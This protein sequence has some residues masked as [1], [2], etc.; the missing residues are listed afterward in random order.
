MIDTSE[1]PHLLSLQSRCELTQ[2]EIHALE[3][4][5]FCAAHH[6]T[7]AS[8]DEAFMKRHPARDMDAACLR[9]LVA[10]LGNAK[11]LVVR[12]GCVLD[13]G[14]EMANAGEARA[15]VL[16]EV[17]HTCGIDNILECDHVQL[18]PAV[19]TQLKQCRAFSQSKQT[20]HI[21]DIDS[22]SRTDFTDAK[23]GKFARRL[24]DLFARAGL[25]CSTE[26]KQQRGKPRTY[27]VIMD[28]EQRD[29]M[30]RLVKL[31]TGTTTV[32]DWCSLGGLVAAA[33][34]PIIWQYLQQLDLGPYS[35]YAR[36][37]EVF[38]LD[39]DD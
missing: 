25:S 12:R 3:R 18:T 1:L 19:L 35:K 10:A 7:N 17:W 31:A 16:A 37:S 14:D 33:K 4:H 34:A 26:G 24:C 32:A 9:V 20:E 30:A 21:F 36:Q 28:V 2:P 27:T 39:S 23:D 8:L 29:A 6:I 15:S 22:R 11:L 38:D 13:D 5:F